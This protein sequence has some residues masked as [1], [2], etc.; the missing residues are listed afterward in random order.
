MKTKRVEATDGHQLPGFR[1]KCWKPQSGARK[2]SLAKFVTISRDSLLADRYLKLGGWVK[3]HL[4]P[5]IYQKKKSSEKLRETKMRLT[6]TTRNSFEKVSF[7]FKIS[8][9]L[10][11]RLK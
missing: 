6:Q 5:G 8:K 2:P 10:L 4:F 7:I 1:D 3:T 9:L 11:R